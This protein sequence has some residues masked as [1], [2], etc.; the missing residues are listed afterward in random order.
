MKKL[1]LLSLILLLAWLTIYSCNKE[2]AT[3][4][5]GSNPPNVPTNPHPAD[6][7]D[8]V[9]VLTFLSWSDSYPPVNPLAYDVYLGTSSSPPL[10]ESHHVTKFYFPGILND[11]VTY[12]WKI[13][14]RDNQGSTSEG[15]LWQFHPFAESGNNPPDTVSNPWPEDG[16]TNIAPPVTLTWTGGDPDGDDVTYHLYWGLTEALTNHAHDIDTTTYTLLNITFWYRHYWKV[17]AEDEHGAATEGPLWEFDAAPS[18]DN[19][20][21]DVPSNPSPPDSATGVDTAEVILSWTCSDPDGDDLAYDLYWGTTPNMMNWAFNLDST[22]YRLINL[23]GETRYYWQVIAEDEHDYKT[24]GPVWTFWTKSDNRPP[25][26]PSNPSPSDGATGVD[27]VDVLLS[28]VCSD[29]DG[30]SLSYTVRW[31]TTPEMI[32]GITDLAY[33]TFVI[34][35]LDSGTRYYWKV[36]A[37]DEHG[38]TAEGPIWEFSTGIKLTIVYRSIYGPYSNCNV[39]ID[40]NRAYLARDYH[41]LIIY[42]ITDPINTTELGSTTGGAAHDIA[43]SGNYAFA[44]GGDVS[45]GILSVYD[46]SNPYDPTYLGYLGGFHMGFGITISDSYAYIADHTAG[47]KVVGIS[48]P[49]MPFIVSTLQT[50]DARDVAYSDGYIYLADETAGLKVIDVSDPHNPTIVYSMG[51]CDTRHWIGIAVEGNRAYIARD[52][53]GLYIMDITNPMHPSDLGYC[54]TFYAHNVAVSGNY[55]YVADDQDGI[56]AIDISDPAHPF[57][58]GS[59]NTNKALGVAV[60][61]SYIYVADYG[62]F[63]IIQQE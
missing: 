18:S 25:N 57:I 30:D 3:E 5:P 11:G 14:A 29:P 22:S 20:P 63:V 49:A 53:Q 47:L 46:V 32:N 23:S 24:E 16:A 38:A 44:A 43:I 39:T 33:T 12:F 35:D 58:A 4:P 1:Y 54:V 52:Y 9:S 13:I 42:D 50:T 62:S 15:P 36:L 61:G 17:I 55:T 21:P 10:I 7:E 59:C 60:R 26:V 6:N 40:G 41:G 28:W 27:T 19:R 34:Y 45:C 51:D 2:N 8:S 37:E 31:G 48:N 56:K